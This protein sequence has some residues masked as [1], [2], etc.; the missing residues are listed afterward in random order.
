[1]CH[2]PVCYI[3]PIYLSESERKS[4]GQCEQTVRGHFTVCACVLVSSIFIDLNASYFNSVKSA[5]HLLQHGE[6]KEEKEI[7]EKT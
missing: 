7:I 2:L 1:M 6:N 3:Q 4:D 5:E